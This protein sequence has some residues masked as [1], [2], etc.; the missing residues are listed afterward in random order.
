MKSL[1]LWGSLGVALAGGLAVVPGPVRAQQDAAATDAAD[2]GALKPELGLQERQRL[3][4]ELV[5]RWSVYVQETYGLDPLPWQARVLSVAMGADAVNL[6]QALR[7]DTFEGAWATLKGRGGANDDEAVLDALVEHDGGQPDALG[8]LERDLVYTAVPPCRIVDTRL[9][10]GPIEANSSRGFHA[11]GFAS[12]ADQGGSDTN[13]GM[14]GQSPEVVMLSV[15]AVYPAIAGYAT[16]YPANAVEVP[17]IANVN[18]TAGAIVNNAVAAKLGTSGLVDFRIYTR[19]ASHYVVDILGYF[20]T[21]YATALSCHDVYNA[22]Q[23][24]IPLGQFVYVQ[25]GGIQACT[26]GFTAV[27]YQWDYLGGD[28]GL[29]V[30]QN[31]LGQGLGLSHTPLASG[32]SDITALIGRRCCRVPGR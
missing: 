1:V 13:C 29:A 2:A 24:V 22:T 21:P 3:G 27:G 25:D 26:T 10:G 14:G 32:G 20:D 9:A 15:A 4:S 30:W 12:Y 18:Y 6:Q 17:L 28:G 5:K 8:D 31:A 11:W 7:R 19:G 16:V 23:T